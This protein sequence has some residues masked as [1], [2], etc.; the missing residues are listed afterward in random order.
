MFSA[1][2][3]WWGVAPTSGV[4]DDAASTTAPP[5]RASETDERDAVGTRLS[6]SMRLSFPSR[7]HARLFDVAARRFPSAMI[8][9]GPPP[10]PSFP[11]PPLD[12]DDDDPL[13]LA[14]SV[15]YARYASVSFDAPP[16]R[17][18]ESA[19]FARMGFASRSAMRGSTATSPPSSV[20]DAADPSAWSRRFLASTM[21]ERGRDERDTRR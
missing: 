18:L 9:A 20:V 12:D 21:H 14:R 17:S 11:F 5:P 8:A 19:R 1:T 16:S 15:R 6:A 2:R 10:P 4:D 13:S 3:A 7:R